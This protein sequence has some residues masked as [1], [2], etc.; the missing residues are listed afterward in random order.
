LYR[1]IR[2]DKIISTAAR[3]VDRVRERF[4]EAG[5]GQV[6]E[7]ILAVARETDERCRMIRR[8]NLPLRLGVVALI[9]L[10]LVLGT[11]VV[12]N[13]RMT[14]AVWDASNFAQAS[15]SLLGDVVFLGAAIAFLVTLETR[16]K[17]GRAL[18]A[19]NELRALAHIIDMHQLTKD[20]E[21]VLTPHVATAASPQR[22]MTAF[23]L[24]R[25]LDYCSEMLALVSKIAALYVQSFPDSQALAAVDEI[26]S[27]TTELSQKIWQK[28]MILDRYSDGAARG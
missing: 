12:R 20:P 3:L 16:I 4:P 25:Y 1:T 28:I 5:L 26:E 24:N 19:I 2:A 13:V 22:N 6:A 23:E 27:L 21:M 17:R 14:E 10:G 15:E 8:P 7:E 18:A 9:V 11:L